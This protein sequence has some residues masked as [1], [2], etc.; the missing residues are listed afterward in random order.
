MLG[1]GLSNPLFLTLHG[2]AMLAHGSEPVG[3]G[4]CSGTVGGLSLRQALGPG[5]ALRDLGLRR[6][7]NVVDE[8]LHDVIT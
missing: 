3:V 4:L 1:S 7:E 5:C 2:G 8:E 6:D